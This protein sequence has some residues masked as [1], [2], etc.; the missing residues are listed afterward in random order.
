MRSVEEVHRA[1]HAQVV[2]H[3]VYPQEKVWKES[4]KV[5][6]SDQHCWEVTGCK[7]QAMAMDQRGDHGSQNLPFHSSIYHQSPICNCNVEG[8]AQTG[9]S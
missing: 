7:D 5:T 6:G 3:Y 9:R 8:Q 4:V 2:T 1:L